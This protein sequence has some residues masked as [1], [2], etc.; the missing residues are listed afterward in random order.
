MCARDDTDELDDEFETRIQ[1]QSDR[2]EKARHEKDKS[3]WLYAGL[4][5]AVGWSVVV[6][7]VLGILLGLWLDRKFA[8]GFKW[9]FGLLIFG[10]MIGCVNAWR[11]IT[12]EQ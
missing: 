4:I 5:G 12:K 10:L 6:P 1:R 2:I 3:F 7:M 9:T 8:G 11:M